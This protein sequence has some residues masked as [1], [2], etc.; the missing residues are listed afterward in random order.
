M[1]KLIIIIT[2]EKTPTGMTKTNIDYVGDKKLKKVL[3]GNALRDLWIMVDS[4]NSEANNLLKLI[5]SWFK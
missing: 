4:K 2:E 3:L 5:E 1:K